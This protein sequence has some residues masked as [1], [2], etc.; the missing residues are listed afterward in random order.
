[1]ENT[2]Y[3]LKYRGFD[4]VGKKDENYKQYNYNS[5]SYDVVGGIEV[6]VYKT[7][8]KQ[9]VG[10]RYFGHFVLGHRLSDY[11]EK[12]FVAAARKF[13]DDYYVA[14]AA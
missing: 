13:I 3:F 8:D 5:F 1:M 7:K 12:A 10:P 6:S 2:N 11:S 9:H 14:L 4:I